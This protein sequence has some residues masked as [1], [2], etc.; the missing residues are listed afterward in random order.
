MKTT[1]KTLLL[2]LVLFTFCQNKNFGTTV[3]DINIDKSNFEVTKTTDNKNNF[4]FS[5][6]SFH[7][8][9]LMICSKNE[10]ENEKIEIFNS[11]LSYLFCNTT[12][13]FPFFC[14]VTIDLTTAKFLSSRLYLQ[15][16]CLRL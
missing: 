10:L 4:S 12:N 8:S 5:V 7:H 13:D 6:L 15:F 2:T 3:V 14:T 9:F 11:F 16:S 1:I